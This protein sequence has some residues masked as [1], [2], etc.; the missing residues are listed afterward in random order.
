MN[1]VRE[2]I[3]FTRGLDPKRAMG[4]GD[5]PT[6]INNAIKEILENDDGEKID[7]IEIKT[8]H[9]VVSKMII[10][11]LPKRLK[12]GEKQINRSTY[13][14]SL[15]I[16][17]GISEFFDMNNVEHAYHAV[18]DIVFEIKPECIEYFTAQ[19]YFINK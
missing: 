2:H 12:L 1:L 18:Y 19:K 8:T 13:A 4:I 9:K 6:R 15:V 3:N 14:A 10:Y 17:A 11:F 5:K 7:Y 16:N